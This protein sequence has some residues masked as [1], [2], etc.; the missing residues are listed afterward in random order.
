MIRPHIF[1]ITF[2]ATWGPDV[3][4]QEAEKASKSEERTSLTAIQF[5]EKPVDFWG[6]GRPK[7]EQATA[8]TSSEGSLRETIW[9]EPTRLPDGRYAIYVP[10]KPVL[11]FLEDPTPDNLKGYLAWKKERAEK[12]R[13]ALHLL[14]EHRANAV[15]TTKAVFAGTPT[16]VDSQDTRG[17][18]SRGAS[19]SS[20]DPADLPRAKSAAPNDERF[21]VTYFHKKGCPHCDTQDAVLAEWMKRHP[22]GKLRVLEFGESP[23][24]WTSLG[25]VGTPA[26]LLSDAEG[27]RSILLQGLAQESRLE[28]ALAELLG[29]SPL[30]KLQ[31]S[32]P[33]AS[34]AVNR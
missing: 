21:L 5:F 11:D 32:E 7:P 10:P 6:T 8:K 9:A 1:V 13:R 4:G 14:E 2:L 29:P 17:L 27:K 26:L 24:L 3:W 30:P 31:Q 33:G 25:I 19:P 12:L 20:Q 28:N 23:E 18:T 15:P 16:K 22:E 34:R